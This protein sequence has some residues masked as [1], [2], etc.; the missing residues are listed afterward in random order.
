MNS[1]GGHSILASSPW[2]KSSYFRKTTST[3]TERQ[4]AFVIGS[5]RRS[6]CY[7]EPIFE[8]EPISCVRRV[9]AP[10]QVFQPA[11]IERVY[12]VDFPD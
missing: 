9:L 12:R 11:Y 6:W 5:H 7:L 8:S 2:R 3:A 10:G 4:M 1:S